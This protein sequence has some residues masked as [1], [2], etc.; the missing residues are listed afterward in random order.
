VA[1]GLISLLEENHY[2][3]PEEISAAWESWL[4]SESGERCLDGCAMGE[5]L[6]NRLWY[7]FMAGVDVGLAGTRHSGRNE[8]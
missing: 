8:P 2:M 1:R 5:Y 6:R 4:R 3:K 7:A